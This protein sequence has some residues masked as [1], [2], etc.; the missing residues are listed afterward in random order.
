M[1]DRNGQLVAEPLTRGCAKCRLHLELLATAPVVLPS[2]EALL[3]HVDLETSGLNPLEDE[4][5]ELGAVA[6]RCGARFATTVKPTQ[7]PDNCEPTVHGIGADELVLSPPFKDVFLRFAT[8]LDN[9]ADNAVETSESDSSQPQFEE[10]ILRLRSPTPRILL[11][12]HN[13]RKF[14]FPFMASEALR[15]GIPLWRFETWAYVDTMVLG[16]AAA[17]TVGT[18]C[19]K[20]QCLGQVC[21]TSDNRA[22]R[23]LDDTLLL[24]DVVSSFAARCGSSAEQL[25]APQAF[26]IDAEQTLLNLSFA[27]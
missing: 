4:I 27:S 7:M 8:F 16:A 14:D 23:A 18:G 17:S 20:L 6:H 24:R 9:L 2:R 25:L 10:R 3:V 15:C 26:S 11:A 5:V 19:A 12:A 21:K 22:H 1:R 13:G